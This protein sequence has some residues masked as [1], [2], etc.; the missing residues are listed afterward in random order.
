MNKQEKKFLI[1]I[2][3]QR[4]GSS[5]LFQYLSDHPKIRPSL[6]KETKFFLPEDYRI[7]KKSRRPYDGKLETYLK[8]FG[9][10]Q[11][12]SDGQWYLDSSP[13]FLN[14][15]ETAVRINEFFKGQELQLVAILRDPVERFLSWYRY[16]KMLGNI[17]REMTL[18]QYLQD[19]IEEHDHEYCQRLKTGQYSH[20]LKVYQE[21][22][23]DRLTIY[24]FEELKKDKERLIDQLLKN[25]GLEKGNFHPQDDKPK[26][27]SY[28]IKFPLLNKGYV[29]LRG[30][31][32]DMIPENSKVY[33]G[34][35]KL[36]KKYQKLNYKPA[37]R[38]PIDSRL[39]TKLKTYY[40]EEYTFLDQLEAPVKS[41]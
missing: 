29:F 1:I 41:R 16:D 30:K 17:D 31:F 19:N 14:S 33:E 20:Y 21:L 15:P 9:A 32:R 8:F 26:N 13:D 3:G 5:A 39:L 34:L 36:S 23:P 12:L 18:K 4:C 40:Q 10:P 24:R 6:Q 2:G 7:K 28:D 11:N 35:R 25:I 22:F 38:E 27:A 37:Q